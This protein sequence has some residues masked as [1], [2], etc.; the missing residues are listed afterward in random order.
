MGISDFIAADVVYHR[1]CHMTFLH[2]KRQQIGKGRPEDTRILAC[3]ERIYTLLENNSEECQFS[4]R[5]LQTLSEI[6][7]YEIYNHFFFHSTCEC[8]SLTT[9]N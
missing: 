9:F 4:V 7:G 5:E 8:V 1:H 2:K 3:M 6:D